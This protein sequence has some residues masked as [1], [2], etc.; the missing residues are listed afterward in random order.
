MG[1]LS[2]V[3][4]RSDAP[5]RVTPSVGWCLDG[6]WADAPVAE[7]ELPLGSAGQ[8]P[9]REEPRFIEPRAEASTAATVAVPLGERTA[10]DQGDPLQDHIPAKS[11]TWTEPRRSWGPRAVLLSVLGAVAAW[12]AIQ[13]L[14]PSQNPS[15]P[16]GSRQVV[17]G[18][19]QDVGAAPEP[20]VSPQ[21]VEAV[22]AEVAKVLA[23]VAG[24]V[25]VAAAAPGKVE[26]LGVVD[27]DEVS[28]SLVRAATRITPHLKLSL[29]T[30]SDLNFRLQAVAPQLGAGLQVKPGDH[31]DVI[32][33]GTVSSLDLVQEAKSIIIKE[34]PAIFEV[35]SEV[36]TVQQ[37]EDE[38]R[39]E[40]AAKAPKVPTLPPLAAVVSGARPY[41]VL[42]DG[43]K[44]QPGGVV[45]SLR[46]AEIQPEVVIFEDERGGRFQM[47]R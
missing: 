30:R 39:R 33:M 2:L 17:V 20:N 36:K 42:A 47:R 26:L 13:A 41:V 27:S 29:L 4:E 8:D 38:A 7:A 37:Q 23:P 31:G 28:E 12:V 9:Q 35:K 25:R 43:H 32:L 34:L 16:T 5:W 45:G 22:R 10:R 40:A 11:A 18:A 21:V 14:M 6:P 44:V 3:L 1:G 24:R 15:A 46:L 19:P